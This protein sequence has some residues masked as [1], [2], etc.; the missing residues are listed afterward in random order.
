MRR[1]IE[2]DRTKP[3][4]KISDS[5]SA[6][7]AALRTEALGWL[8]RLN[9][10]EATPADAEAFDRWRASSPARAEEF[11]EAALFWSVLGDAAHKA[12]RDRA[13]LA[14]IPRPDRRLA[15]RGF[16]VGGAALA[17][18][19]AGALALR[20]P[21]EL[22]P[23]VAELA[24][25]YRTSRG[26]RRQIEIENFAAIELNT[27]TSLDL[28]PPLDGNARVELITGEAAV[29]SR[30]SAGRELV[31]IAGN[32]RVA[33]REASFNI[34]KD[35]SSV[36]VSCTAGTVAV[37]CRDSTVTIRMGQQ[38]AYDDQGTGEIMAIDPD[39]IAAWQR[40]LLMFRRAPLSHVID[41]VNRYR[42]GRVV[43]L[44]AALGRRQVVANFRLDRI[45]DVVDFI[46]K[47]MGIRIRS[48]PGGVV[49]VG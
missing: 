33:S 26:E 17:A 30:G 23:S 34:R 47:A 8:R 28:H 2:T 18:S 21:L 7:R 24:A 39:M 29:S 32:G 10:G 22:W 9:S 5:D 20:P 6:N 27:R 43:L 25:D 41:E 37:S 38:V 1:S 3:A 49:L 31:V 46:S 4:M 13:V 45:E 19:A 11:A 35:G 12:E 40:G 44:D 15:R 42:A 36:S 48:L 16:L 14:L